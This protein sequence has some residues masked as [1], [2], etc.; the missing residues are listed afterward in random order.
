MTIKNSYIC[1]EIAI[2]RQEGD[3][4][5]II[6]TVPDI[7]LLS[8]FTEVIFQCYKS[9]TLIMDKRLSYSD[10]QLIVSGQDIIINLKPEDTV[11][12]KGVCKGEIQISGDKDGQVITVVKLL[13]TILKE[14]ITENS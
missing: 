10:A 2:E 1:S 7:L 12:N 4:G 5:S 6:V 9:G 13:I 14:I 11:G 3:T 8:D